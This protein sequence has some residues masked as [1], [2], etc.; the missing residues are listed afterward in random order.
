VSVRSVVIGIILLIGVFLAVAGIYYAVQSE[1]WKDLSAEQQQIS[2]QGTEEDNKKPE[3][4]AGNLPTFDIVRVDPEGTAV[5]AGRG[6][7]GAEISVLA[8]GKVIA[9]ETINSGGEWAVVVETPL[10]EGPQELTLSM[11]LPDGTIVEGE[12]KVVIAVPDRPD[13]NPLVVL[14]DSEGGSRI[15]QNPDSVNIGQ[16]LVIE[17]IDYDEKGNV[18]FSGRGDPGKVVRVYVDNQLVGEDIADPNGRW[19]VTP[20][21]TITPGVHN[22]RADQLDSEGLVTARIELPFEREDPAKLADFP[23][24]VI[25]QPGNSLWRLSRRLYG[26]GILY[27][28]IYQANKDQIRDPDLIYPGQVFETP[29]PEDAE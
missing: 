4:D 18:V 22:L 26:R 16:T 1:F 12:Q 13:R 25:V 15:L 5:I 2:T 10:D 14:G 9:T 11:K 27:T 8:G 21:I 17:A 23:G 24:R 7:P 3:A 20:T 6:V 19:S 29:E 28:V